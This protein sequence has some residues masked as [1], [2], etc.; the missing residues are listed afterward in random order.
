M[1]FVDA[2]L[3][4]TRHQIVVKIFSTLACALMLGLNS[5]NIGSMEDQE[6]KVTAAPA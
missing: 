5:G 6:T 2:I 4:R 3:T 1:V